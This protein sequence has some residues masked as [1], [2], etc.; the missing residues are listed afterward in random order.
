MDLYDAKATTER[1]IVVTKTNSDNV[2]TTTTA[3]PLA[4][5]GDATSFAII[6]VL[7]ACR[8]RASRSTASCAARRED[9]AQK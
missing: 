1:T 9:D 5:T 4:K 7:A 2:T 3:G 6:G 8:R